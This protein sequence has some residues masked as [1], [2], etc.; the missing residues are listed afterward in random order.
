MLIQFSVENFQSIKKRVTLDM[1]ALIN[2]VSEKK[3]SLIQG[4]LLPLASIYGPNGGG[5]STLLKAFITLQSIVTSFS[6]TRD[7]VVNPNFPFFRRFVTPFKF[8]KDSVNKPTIFEIYLR[9]NN[10]EYKYLLSLHETIIVNEYLYKKTLQDKE[11]CLEFYRENKTINLGKDLQS[12]NVSNV[13]ES[14]PLLVFIEQFYDIT[15]V[16][17][18]MNWFRKTFTID[19]NSPFQEEIMRNNLYSIEL[20]KNNTF[21]NKIISILKEMDLNIDSYEVE[22]Q[23]INPQHIKFEINTTHIVDNVEYKLLLDEESNGTRKIFSILPLLLRALEEGR[24]I[25][26]DEFDAKLHPVLMQY[27]IGL[28]NNKVINING[29]QLIFTSHDLINMNSSNFRRDEIWFMYVNEH[30]YS[31]LYS[32]I[33]LRS[34]N[35]GIVRKDAVFSKQYLEGKYG[36]DPYLKKIYKWGN[37]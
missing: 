17:S 3:D 11:S 34:D 33:D 35:G 19:Y 22:K 29:A 7:G 23:Q 18:V 1:R 13:S 27:I 28:F 20:T 5:K 26:I 8:D 14:V 16:K 36:A 6:N 12:I 31:E 37:I 24:T 4:N 21:K 2:K 10:V 25:V 30:Q 32:L 15:S 9:I